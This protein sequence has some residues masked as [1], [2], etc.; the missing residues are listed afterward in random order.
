MAGVPY[1]VGENGP[2]LM[3]PNNAGTVMTNNRTNAMMG[4]SSSGSS[5][6]TIVQNITVNGSMSTSERAA[7]A[8]QVEASTLAAAAEAK[9][10]GR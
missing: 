4:G 3:I 7:F 2:E 9:K 8:K 6:V 1:I 10:R 5:G